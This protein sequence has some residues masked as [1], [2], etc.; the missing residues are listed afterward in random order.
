MGSKVPDDERSIGIV[1]DSGDTALDVAAFVASAAP[2]IGG[3]ISNVLGGISTGRKFKRVS[4]AL[5]GLAEDLRNFK[6]EV[7][8]KYVKTEDFEEL[9]EETLRRIATER[10][11]EKR[12][13]YRQFLVESI[14]NPGPPYD[15][16]LRLLRTLEQIQPAHLGVLL[17][18]D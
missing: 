10:A 3:P 1:R 2:W 7:S 16:Q 5:H 14:K 17:A 8:E 6:S 18:L 12:R 13:V 15:E 4:E 11:E 9:L